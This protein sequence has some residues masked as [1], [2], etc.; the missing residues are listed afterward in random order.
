MQ[1]IFRT[2]EFP[3]FLKEAGN[4]VYIHKIRLDHLHYSRATQTEFTKTDLMVEFEE[5]IIKTL[6]YLAFFIGIALY[7]NMHVGRMRKLKRVWAWGGGGGRPRQA[8]G[9]TDKI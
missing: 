6:V 5:K 4:E 2:Q 1:K 7:S 3:L 9:D 8:T